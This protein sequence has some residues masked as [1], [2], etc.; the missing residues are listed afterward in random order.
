MAPNQ[1]L[2]KTKPGLEKDW[3]TQELT[4][5]IQE[6]WI[7]EGRPRQGHTY[8]ERLRVR[9]TYKNAI[10]REKKATKQTAWNHLHVAMEMQ[11][12]NSFWKYWR[13]VYSKNNKADRSA[14]SRERWAGALMEVF[15][16][17]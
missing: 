1:S 14:N 17:L 15:D 9:A 11:D 3:W 10:R 16:S 13:S 12:T 2:P 7:S 4:I 5:A 6:V 8:L